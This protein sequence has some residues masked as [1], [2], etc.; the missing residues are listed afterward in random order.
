MRKKKGWI[1][2]GCALLLGVAVCLLGRGKS[3]FRDLDASQIAYAQVQLLPPDKTAEIADTKAL[4]ALLQ[5]VVI[6]EKDDSYRKYSG[7]AA[8]FTLT[9][10]DGT[11]VEI[12]AYN[13]FLVI[14]GAG[15]KTKYAPCEALNGYANQ[16]LGTEYSPGE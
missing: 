15:Y 6:Y 12:M 5:D 7:Q 4:A 1:I 8:I 13:P 9:M 2:P 3:P 11:Q 16:L 10:T 14:D